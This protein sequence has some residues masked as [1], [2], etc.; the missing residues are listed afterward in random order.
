MNT[1]VYLFFT[2]FC[3]TTKFIALEDLQKKVNPTN[4]EIIDEDLRNL[5]NKI[6]DESK[7]ILCDRR[8]CYVF[9]FN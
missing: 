5:Q 9:F 7:N 3:A 8:H 2:S 4:I 6:E 1:D